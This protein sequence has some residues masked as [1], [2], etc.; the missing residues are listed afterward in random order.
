[1][2]GRMDES[3]IFLLL[4]DFDLVER[5]VRDCVN[6]YMTRGFDPHC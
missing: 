1:M 4:A 5:N 2:L 3:G 6:T